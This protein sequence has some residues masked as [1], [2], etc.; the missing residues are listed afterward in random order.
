[1]STVVGLFIQLSVG[2]GFQ[3]ELQKIK[4]LSEL[5]CKCFFGYVLLLDLGLRHGNGYCV[6][7]CV[8]TFPFPRAVPVYTAKTVCKCYSSP[9]LPVLL[10]TSHF[11][12]PYLKVVVSY[13]C[14]IITDV[15]Y[16]SCIFAIHISS[17]KYL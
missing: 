8:L 11:I 16:F 7:Q 12:F 5:M 3:V 6:I 2:I 9:P 15:G 14:L 4:L 17:V 10:M 1:M 13:I